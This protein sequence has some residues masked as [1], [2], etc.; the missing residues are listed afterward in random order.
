[1]PKWER[2]VRDGE[3]VPQSGVTD[4]VKGGSPL[5]DHTDVFAAVR[6]GADLNRRLHIREAAVL[7]GQPGSPEPHG[8][9]PRAR[10]EV[11]LERALGDDHRRGVHRAHHGEHPEPQL[12][13][14]QRRGVRSMER[15][16]GRWNAWRSWMEVEC[17]VWEKAA[18]TSMGP[19]ITAIKSTW[20]RL[21][22]LP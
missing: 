19:A 15:L 10:L 14:E 13:G 11:R 7:R 5:E 8:E 12:R 16:E 20:P 3:H 21:T 17:F 4:A 2:K 6:P 22:I 9:E 18:S 1:M